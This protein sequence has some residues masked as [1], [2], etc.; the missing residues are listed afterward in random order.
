MASASIAGTVRK[1]IF[2]ILVQ[3]NSRCL[4]K[5]ISIGYFECPT[6]ISCFLSR[7]VAYYF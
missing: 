6:I 5:Q 4:I 1:N 2:A 3:A 7:E